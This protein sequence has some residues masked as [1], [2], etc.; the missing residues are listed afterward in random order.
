ME[1]F[2]VGRSRQIGGKREGDLN[3]GRGNI[4]TRRQGECEV[5]EEKSVQEPMSTFFYSFCF[6]MR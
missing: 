4:G 6:S 5:R 1:E 3:T 2:S